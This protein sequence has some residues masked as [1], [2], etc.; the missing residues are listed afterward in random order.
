MSLSCSPISKICRIPA[1]TANPVEMFVFAF[2]PL[3]SRAVTVD[4]VRNASV[5][6]LSPPIDFSRIGEPPRVHVC[7]HHV[8]QV[9]ATVLRWSLAAGADL[10]FEI[11]AC[12]RTR[13]QSTSP[14]PHL[15]RTSPAPAPTHP[16]IAII[17]TPITD[18]LNALH[19]LT[20]TSVTVFQPTW[21]SALLLFLFVA[22]R[23]LSSSI[24]PT[25]NPFP[26]SP[27]HRPRHAA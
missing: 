12:R 1:K 9:V 24:Q 11:R 2:S 19:I 14:R 22:D 18:I 5:N 6:V 25:G 20:S 8:D 10:R 4:P 23:V 17:E 7:L 26:I 15:A 16:L 13:R 3:T 27:S 21:P